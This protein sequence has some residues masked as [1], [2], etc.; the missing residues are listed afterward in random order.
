MTTTERASI[1]GGDIS[2]PEDT[3]T[4]HFLSLPPE[5]RN[6]IY[7]YVMTVG[8]VYVGLQGDTNKLRG[9]LITKLI[10][11]LSAVEERC[12]VTRSGYNKNAEGDE[13]AAGSECLA[14]LRSCKQ[15][16]KEA[17]QL[18]YVCNTFEVQVHVPES[19]YEDDGLIYGSLFTSDHVSDLPIL[20]SALKEFVD[21]I[22]TANAAVLT[23]VVFT[24]GQVDCQ[25]LQ[26]EGSYV[27]ATIKHL[28]SYLQPWHIARPSWHLRL[29]MQEVL[30]DMDDF[31]PGASSAI[32]AL[33]EI[34]ASKDYQSTEFGY[35]SDLLHEIR[36]TT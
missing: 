3:P 8:T 33:N 20:A 9:F 4:S 23:N 13:Q 6:R 14:L 26:A 31:R 30:L 11:D 5:L 25:D 17:A 7:E 12:K 19:H 18:F 1:G 16:N 15:V 34:V 28:R 24:L 10:R 2:T 21:I 29:E 35:F 27:V 22:G 36:K 32:A